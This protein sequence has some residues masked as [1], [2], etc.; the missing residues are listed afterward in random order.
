M[1]KLRVRAIKEECV[2]LRF[3]TSG[4]LAPPPAAARDGPPLGVIDGLRLFHRLWNW[5][6]NIHW[7]FQPPLMRLCA[8]ITE[9]A[10]SIPPPDRIRLLPACDWA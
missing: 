8:H 10:P 3:L 5:F 1:P 4:L 9:L 6:P 2:V 7:V